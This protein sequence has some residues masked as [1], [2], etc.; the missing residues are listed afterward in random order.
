[1]H[2]EAPTVITATETRLDAILGRLADSQDELVA[3]WAA[4][5]AAE[6]ESA[7]SHPRPNE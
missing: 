3:E 5:L 6:G 2:A 7:S 4:A 1:M